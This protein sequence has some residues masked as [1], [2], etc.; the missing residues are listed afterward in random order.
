[1]GIFHDFPLQ[2]IQFG[3]PPW[4]WTPSTYWCFRS[5]MREWSTMSYFHD[6]HS[7]PHSHPFPAFS[8]S[9]LNGLQSSNDGN[10]ILRFIIM[11]FHDFPWV[12]LINLQIFGTPPMGPSVQ[13]AQRTLRG[14]QTQLQVDLR[15]AAPLRL[16]ADSG[17]VNWWL[18][19]C[20]YIYIYTQ[21][22]LSYI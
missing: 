11:I 8:T 15:L 19:W 20:T 9:K 16:N 7:N 14:S 10:F 17:S 1:M 4:L 5:G 21:C 18:Y 12:S 3:D 22:K 13:G 2:T 6:N